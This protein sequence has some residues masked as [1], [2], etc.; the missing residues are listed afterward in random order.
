M[1]ELLD[2]VFQKQLLQDLSSLYPQRANVQRSWPTQDQSQLLVNLS[3]LAEHRLVEIAR[4]DLMSGEI[5]LHSVVITAHG[6]DFI[7][8]DGG[9]SA[10]LGVVTVRL[11]DDTIRQLLIRKVQATERDASVRDKIVE[12]IRSLP[13]DA[14]GEIALKGLDGAL[15]NIPNA[16]GWLRSLLNL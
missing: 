6:L 14:L 3:Y 7:A 2:R 10:V 16:I 8:N 15:D 13:A 9:L 1:G 4:T 11:H 12:K 5:R